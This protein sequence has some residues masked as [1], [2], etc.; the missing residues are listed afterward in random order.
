MCFLGTGGHVRMYAALIPKTSPH[1]CSVIRFQYCGSMSVP[2]EI[3]IH[4]KNISKSF[5]EVQNMVTTVPEFRLGREVRTSTRR[6]GGTEHGRVEGHRVCKK[7]CCNVVGKHL[8]SEK[9]W[10]IVQP[11]VSVRRLCGPLIPCLPTMAVCTQSM[12]P[13]SVVSRGEMQAATLCHGT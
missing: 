1:T 11:D 9:I 8:L 12:E 3:I 4:G 7:V 2:S 5:S 10:S 13:S 6:T